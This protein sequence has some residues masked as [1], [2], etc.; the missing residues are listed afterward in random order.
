MNGQYPSA[1]KTRFH[2]EVLAGTLIG[3]SLLGPAF[4][5]APTAGMSHGTASMSAP[6]IWVAPSE[7]QD[8]LSALLTS[9]D[10]I[11]LARRLE[12]SL[13]NGDVTRAERDLDAAIEVGTLA[14]IFSEYLRSPNLLPALQDHGIK[15]D[16]PGGSPG[17]PEPAAAA[18]PAACSAT[19]T[20]AAEL[21]QALQQEQAYSGMISKTLTDLMQENNALK[22]RLETE[23]S[24]QTA[25]VIQMQ[26]ALQKEQEQREAAARELEN[27]RNDY[28]TLQET[29]GQTAAPAAVQTAELEARL[30]Q[31]REKNDNA[32]RQLAAM[33]QELHALQ[34]FKNEA[35]A[36]STRSAEIEKALAQERLRSETLVQ[37]LAKASEELRTLREPYQSS[38]TPVVF[39]IARKGADA[40]LPKAEATP[41]PPDPPSLP[42]IEPV[43]SDTTSAVPRSEPAPVVIASLPGDVQPLPVAPKPVE[44]QRASPGMGIKNDAPA[45]TAKKDDRLVARAEELLH[46]G[47]VS[48]A[49]LLL[50]RSMAAGNPRAA[51]LMAETFDP[52]VLSRLKVLGIRGD[53]AR[54]Q[55]FYARARDLG[56]VQAGERLEA[57]K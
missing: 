19:D 21:R 51:F 35:T 50:E 26:Q 24:S 2:T 7:L 41:L 42:R 15:G 53:A 36:A 44:P 45:D 37:E 28:R 16:P 23:T 10:R 57:L 47:D 4:A 55:E 3:L 17:G 12:N 9:Q 29:R 18:A 22:A 20:A 31:E 30:R 56:M 14:A 1:S 52:N 25:T 38:A 11:E 39:R 13:R 32:A 49:R 34:T 43:P 8:L 54:A 27:L 5:E 33:T 46:K 6:D 48:G 40:P